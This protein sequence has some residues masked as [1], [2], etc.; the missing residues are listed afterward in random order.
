MQ[1]LFPDLRYAIR[2]LLKQPVFATVALLTLALGIGANTAMFSLI[3]AVLLRPLSYP[4]ADRLVTF[5]HFEPEKGVQAD[6]PVISYP[7]YELIRD[8]QDIFEDMGAAMFDG[9]TLTG[10]GDPVQLWGCFTSAR[11]LQTLGVQPSRGRLFLP[12]EDRQGG[13]RVAVLSQGC[14]QKRF[15]SDPTIVGRTILLN[16]TAYTV[17]GILAA[18]LAP[19]FDQTDL[20]AP[21][22]LNS[23]QYPPVMFQ[24]G[25]GILFGA[26][27]LKPGIGL[28]RANEALRLMSARYRQTFPDHVDAP[29]GQRVA[30]LQELVVGQ[31]RPTFYTL[32]CAV[33]FVLLIACVNVA[34]LLLARLEGRRKEIAIRAALGASRWRLARQFLTESLVLTLLAGVLGTLLALWCVDLAHGLGPEVVPRAQEIRL[35]G[36]TLVFT[37]AISLA[38]GVLLGVAPALHAASGDAGEALQQAGSRGNAGGVRQGRTRS[39]LLIAQV[40]LSLVL[41]TGT[42]LLL[43]SLWQ[44]QRVHLGFNPNGIA[45]VDI[46]LPAE[47]YPKIEQQ[48]AFFAQ[49]TERLN[50]LPGVKGS[51]AALYGP[52]NGALN[53]FYAVPGQPAAPGGQRTTAFCCYASPD[54][55]KT[56]EVPILRGRT[57]TEGD[58]TG[59]PPVMLISEN[60]ARKLFPDGDAIGRKLLCTASHPTLTEIVGI[61]ADVRMLNAAEP[62]KPEMYFSMYQRAGPFMRV[63]VR[64]LKPEQAKNLDLAIHGVIRAV[65]PDQPAGELV[66]MNTVVARSMGDRRLIALLLASFAGLALV[67]AAIGIYGVT[68]YGVAQR[69]REIGIR[70]A[71]GAQRGDVFRL[72]I[73]GGMKLILAGIVVG[74]GCALGLTRLLASLLYGVGASD[75]LTFAAVVM[76]LA[77]VALLANYLPAR[78]ATQVDPLTALR[79]E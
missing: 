2:T 79:E 26:A 70:M 31:A 39:I 76:L 45:T 59:A 21:G 77:V 3:H 41:L 14:W 62:P 16:N 15:A 23:N 68:A 7:R 72:I 71:L 69:T 24:Q 75:P 6:A 28:E 19:P 67:L 32:A 48:S 60:L 53:M 56:L 4:H 52:L 9:F 46:N 65:D 73:G 25:S 11:L 43:T 74:I 36:T 34:N 49:V 63:Y 55:F 33:G 37:L 1:T 50:A 57:F 54:Y 66:E 35:S 8:Q 5:W 18:P 40:A 30:P 61:V 47:R 17:V 64:T 51:T 12:E 27:R 58:R 13:P 22:I 20:F 38:A 29:A 78:R 10:Q 42:G 44:L